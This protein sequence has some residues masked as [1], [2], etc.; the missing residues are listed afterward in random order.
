MKPAVGTHGFAPKAEDELTERIVRKG[1]TYIKETDV[2][3]AALMSIVEYMPERELVGVEPGKRFAA[4]GS[5]PE[6]GIAAAVG[7]GIASNDVLAVAGDAE[8]AITTT[9]KSLEEDCIR[10]VTLRL[11]PM[12]FLEQLHESSEIILAGHLVC[13]HTACR[14]IADVVSQPLTESL[15]GGM[16]VQGVVDAHPA[17]RKE[18]LLFQFAVGKHLRAEMTQLY[19]EHPVA[20]MRA[21]RSHH[22]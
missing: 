7:H 22:T 1:E 6:I 13:S 18:M 14:G 15:S 2:A 4:K 19:V 8:P 20:Q 9:V 5:V 21:Q 10:Y 17:D 16:A 12:V 3:A 11:Q